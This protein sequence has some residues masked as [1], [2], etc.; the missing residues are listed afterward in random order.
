MGIVTRSRN[1]WAIRLTKNKGIFFI[2]QGRDSYGS[3]RSW[4]WTMFDFL[5]HTDFRKS[6]EFFGLSVEEIVAVR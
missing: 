5:D 1:V 6:N 3:L 2:Y 4:G